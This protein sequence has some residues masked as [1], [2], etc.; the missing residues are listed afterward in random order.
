MAIDRFRQLALAHDVHL[1]SAVAAV[2]L[3]QVFA[4]GLGELRRDGWST[5][6]SSLQGLGEPIFRDQADRRESALFDWDGTLVLVGRH[7]NQVHAAVAAAA[8]KAAEQALARLHEL[9]PAPDLSAR[10][11]VTGMDIEAVDDA[12]TAHDTAEAR[13]RRRLVQRALSK[14]SPDKREVFVL[15]DLEGFSAPELPA[16]MNRKRRDV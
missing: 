8:G 4:R 3:E 13:E 1:E 15:L 2:F 11:E 16:R 5:V 12:P 7:A 14:L 6:E 10:H 9:L